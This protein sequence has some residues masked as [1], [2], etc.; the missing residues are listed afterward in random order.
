MTRASSACGATSFIISK[1]IH[2]P[3]HL[4]TER[5]WQPCLVASLI[6]TNDLSERGLIANNG[7]TVGVSD[8][9]VLDK[10]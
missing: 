2:S 8:D 10:A 1:A 5:T 9:L 4:A 6:Y 3:A 7:C